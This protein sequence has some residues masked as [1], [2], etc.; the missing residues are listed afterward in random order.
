MGVDFGLLGLLLAVA[1]TAL[2]A[3]AFAIGVVY[4]WLAEWKQG[5]S[6]RR[7]TR[8]PAREVLSRERQ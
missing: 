7:A 3:A 1:V 2:F 4:R 8:R 5:R 6:K